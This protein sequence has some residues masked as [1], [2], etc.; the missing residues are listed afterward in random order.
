M[1]EQTPQ[2]FLDSLQ[3][4][5][6]EMVRQ[7][8][9]LQEQLG[10]LTETAT[11]GGVSVTV[12]SNGALQGL[13]FDR[14]SMQRGPAELRD[15]ILR[16]AAQAQ[17]AVAHRVAQTVEPFAG[18]SAMEFLRTQLPAEPDGSAAS[19]NDDPAFDEDEPPQTYLR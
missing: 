11:E 14:N 13:D 7:S 9:Q 5:A 10:S 2:Q 3:G 19:R 15:T 4:R 16:L 6:D 18:A 12:G 8:Q 17:G 1:A